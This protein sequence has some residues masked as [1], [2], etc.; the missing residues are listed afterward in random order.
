MPEMIEEM[1]EAGVGTGVAPGRHR[2]GTEIPNDALLRLTTDYPGRFVALASVD[3]IDARHGTAMIDTAVGQYRFP[4]ISL[5]LSVLGMRVD[6]RRAYP[7]YEHCQRYGCCVAITLS[8]LGARELDLV[9]PADLERAARD[10]P[11]VNFV[12]AHGS[13]PYVLQI[14]AVAMKRENVWIAPDMYMTHAPGRGLYVEAAQGYLQDRML[15]GTGYPY[16]PLRDTVERFQRLPLRETVR[17]KLL[18][19]NAERLLNLNRNGGTLDG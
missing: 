8:A 19:R 1:D 13:H 3:V 2:P 15:F 4:G 9:D 12:S 5:D 7:I 18:H 10:F 11:R 17:E 16:T 14:I 6:D